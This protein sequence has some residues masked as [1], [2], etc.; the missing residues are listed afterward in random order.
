MSQTE[1][2]KSVYSSLSTS[3]LNNNTDDYDDCKQAKAYSRCCECFS[4]FDGE[5]AKP[6]FDADFQ[7]KVS[8]LSLYDSDG[9]SVD[10][11]SY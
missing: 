2:Y 8:S 5:P 9:F 1:V 6:L 11:R 10:C 4:C 7:V 3:I